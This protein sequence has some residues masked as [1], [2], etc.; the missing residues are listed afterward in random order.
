MRN[1]DWLSSDSG[2]QE[3]VGGFDLEDIMSASNIVFHLDSE[4][5]DIFLQ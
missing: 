3:F 2:K 4:A 5:C 1:S